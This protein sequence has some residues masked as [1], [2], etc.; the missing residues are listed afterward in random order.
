MFERLIEYLRTLFNLS[1]TSTDK[2]VPNVPEEEKPTAPEKPV[3]EDKEPDIVNWAQDGSEVQSDTIITVIDEN[4]DMVISGEAAAEETEIGFDGD[5]DN[6]PDVLDDMPDIPHSGAGH[7]PR[8][9]WCLDNGHGKKARGKRSPIFNGNE[10]F[11]EY[12][13]NRDV[14]ERIMRRLDALGVK[15]FDVV[16]DYATVGNI[17]EERV[18]RANWKRSSLPKIYLSIHSNA[19]P[20]RTP[21]DWVIDRISGIE[22][23]F[24]HGSRSGRKLATVFQKRLIGATGWKNRHIKSRNKNQFYVLKKTKMPAVLTENGFYNN[25]K[26]VQALRQDSVRQTIAEAHVRAIMEIEAKGI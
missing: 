8:Y 3:S 25:E 7:K 2:P 9:L 22:T 17:L 6:I 1:D 19:G 23:W 4:K 12:E 13:F 15:Y 18:N 11:F 10:Q 14:V 20:T 16:P 5:G 21:N 24:Y 26:Q